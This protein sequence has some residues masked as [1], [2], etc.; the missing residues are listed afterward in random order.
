[1]LE[2]LA[3][4]LVPLLAAQVPPNPSLGLGELVF[5]YVR[6]TDLQEAK[7]CVSTLIEQLASLFLGKL[8]LL[9]CSFSP[10]SLRPL[11]ESP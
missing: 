2:A 4:D 10:P 6:P 3:E 5:Y 9:A 11:L 1:M 7:G 8:F